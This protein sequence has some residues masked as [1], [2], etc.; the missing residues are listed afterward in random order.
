[1]TAQ[2][3]AAGAAAAAPG[4]G[5]VALA[6]AGVQLGGRW[7][8]QGVDLVVE[9]GEFLVVLGPNGA[10]KTTL[11]RV[12]LGLAP[13]AAGAV[14]VFGVDPRRARPLVGYVPQRGSIG[15]DLY[16]RARDF[17]ALGV[18]GTRFGVSLSAARRRAKQEMVRDAIEAVGG[19]AFADRAVG[20]LSGGEQQRLLLA[21]ALVMRPRLLLLDEPLASLDLRG[22]TQASTLV[23]S[24]ARARGITVVLV[25]HD[26]NPLVSVLDRVAYVARGRMAAG[27]PDEVITSER[28][29]ALYDT[30]VEVL[31]DSV[32]RVVVIGLEDVESHHD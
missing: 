13:L 14:R 12:I 10:G 32:G 30:P 19:S 7:V 28:L 22:Q 23:A 3:V 18:D 5:A 25:A 17:V 4:R 16:V 2:Q 29:S 21:Q 6:D 20:H 11:L 8:W 27:T 24:V 15:R 1:M 26:V 31:R 9:E